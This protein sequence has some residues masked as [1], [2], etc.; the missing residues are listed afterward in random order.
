MI[1]VYNLGLVEAI[2]GKLDKEQGREIKSKE[3]Y[4]SEGDRDREG[5]ETEAN[6]ER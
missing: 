5:E 1:T 6:I 3:K 4:D 2:V